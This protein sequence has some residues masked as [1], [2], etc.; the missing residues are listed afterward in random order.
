MSEKE[1]FDE[2]FEDF[3]NEEFDDEYAPPK[4]G[5][6]CEYCGAPATTWIQENPACDDCFESAY[7]KLIYD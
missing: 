7:E 1:L 3:E 2:E 5:T 6:E 4:K